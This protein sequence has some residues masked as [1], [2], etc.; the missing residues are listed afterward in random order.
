MQDLRESVL[1]KTVDILNK[2]NIKYWVSDGTLLGI[3]RDGGL[4]PWDDDIDIAIW[5]HENNKNDIVNI[6]EKSKYN[7]VPTLADMDCLHFEVDGFQVDIG[8]YERK[9]YKTSIKWATKPNSKLNRFFLTVINAIF[10]CENFS[11][12]SNKSPIKEILKKIIGFIGKVLSV[13]MRE[14][15]FSFASG[16]YKYIGS[17]YDNAL[18][19]FQECEFRNRSIIVPKNSEEY[20]RLTYGNDWK[21]PNKEYVWENDTHNLKEFL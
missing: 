15:L 6:F 13:K 19:S 16:K 10:E 4:I 5:K 3:I 7:V 12:Y 20:L 1:F 17:E 18:M 14:S 2:N 11:S 8:F 9:K 21:R